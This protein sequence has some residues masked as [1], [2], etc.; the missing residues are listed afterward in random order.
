MAVKSISVNLSG[1]INS[2][3][4]VQ[5]KGLFQWFFCELFIKVPFQ[6]HTA[7]SWAFQVPQLPCTTS[8]TLWD[9]ILLLCF[10]CQTQFHMSWSLLQGRYFLIGWFRT[11]LWCFWSFFRGLG[12]SWRVL[13]L[14]FSW[15]CFRVRIIVGSWW[16]LQC[17]DGVCRRRGDW[18]G[19]S[20]GGSR[21]TFGG[22]KRPFIGRT[23][24]QSYHQVF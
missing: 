6:K 3:Q 8:C 22:I 16:R 18:R 19:E 9:W 21:S 13:L 10:K 1:E 12:F 7:K 23:W 24:W 4:E 2:L 20:C 5:A 14:S 11:G 17:W 15:W